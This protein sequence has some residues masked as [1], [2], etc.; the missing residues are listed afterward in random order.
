MIGNINTI[1]NI[2]YF[3]G[4]INL[5]IKKIMLYFKLSIYS[6]IMYVM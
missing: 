6:P 2:K 3:I 4:R 1:I 5:I